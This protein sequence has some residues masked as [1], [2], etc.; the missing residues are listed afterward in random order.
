MIDGNWNG[1]IGD[2]GF[3]GYFQRQTGGDNSLVTAPMLVKTRGYLPPEA[4]DG[5]YSLKSDVWSYG[6]VSIMICA[7][8]DMSM[9]VYYINSISYSLIRLV[10]MQVVLETYSGAKAYDEGRKDERLV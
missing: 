5:R 7:H 3:S 8:A 2:F 1:K 9:D 4:N 10:H 6:I